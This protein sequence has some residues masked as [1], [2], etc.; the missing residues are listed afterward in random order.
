MHQIYKL[1]QL[2]SYQQQKHLFISIT[3]PFF[4]IF[5]FFIFSLKITL[6]SSA[7]LTEPLSVVKQG[8]LLSEMA[9][10][11]SAIADNKNV[12]YVDTSIPPILDDGPFRFWHEKRMI[13]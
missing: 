1:L 2:I 7:T 3:W 5:S 13:R 8:L 9:S 10:A 11:S 12:F 6:T 4:N